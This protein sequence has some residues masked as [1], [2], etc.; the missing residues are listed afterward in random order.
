M[1]QASTVRDWHDVTPTMFRDE[2][3]PLNEPA[4]LR[5]VMHDWPAVRAGLTSPATM[6]AYLRGFDRGATVDT[7]IGDPSIE[8]RFF[9]NDT[10]TGFNFERHPAPVA[11][12]LA[13]ML[14]LLD[15]TAPPSIY[16]GAVPLAQ[17]MPG[18]LQENALAVVNPAV[19]PRIWISNRVTVQT[20]HDMSDNLA[21]VVCGRR[22]FTLFPPEQVANLYVGPLEFTLAGPPVSL[23]RL[24]N[25][26]YQKYPR[27]RAALPTARYADLE[28][29]DA[30]FIPYMWWHHVE[31]LDRFNVLVN[32][33]WNDAPPY[34]GTPFDAMLYG[35][36]SIRGLPPER[37]EVWRK[38][39]DHYVFQTAGNPVEHLSAR[40]RG[41]Q[42]E[43]TPQVAAQIRA[44]LLRALSGK[45]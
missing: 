21:C 25:P 37:R 42:G 5:R 35:L 15:A 26:D 12:T 32:Y 27:F 43:L 19:P 7:M 18:F 39:F 14:A 9:Y 45:P 22:R 34:T 33:W 44:Y 28:P 30:L 16:I 4:V 20:H 13:R 10:L 1:S 17:S 11:E 24:E 31:S 23:V 6:A 8:G 29:G 3:A 36:M 40:Q 38:F 41:V 2:I